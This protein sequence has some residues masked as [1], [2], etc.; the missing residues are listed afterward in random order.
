[1]QQ[2]PN[3]ILYI[4]TSLTPLESDCEYSNPILAIADSFR[5]R[6]AIKIKPL[7]KRHHL[8]YY[9]VIQNATPKVATCPSGLHNSV[10]LQQSSNLP[11]LAPPVNPCFFL[12][13]RVFPN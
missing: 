3:Q 8:T 1:M 10:P 7:K 6:T 5:N 9:T 11:E 4:F 13:I 2:W 12:H